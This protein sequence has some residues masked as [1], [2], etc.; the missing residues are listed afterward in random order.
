[1][2]VNNMYG[3]TALTGGVSGCLDA[4]NGSRLK[5]GDVD[6]VMDSGAN[7]SFYRLNETS[8]AA[9]S[10]PTVIS[11]DTNAGSKRHI[12]ASATFDHIHLVNNLYIAAGK[13][14]DYAG[15]GVPGMTSRLLD[16]Y[17]R[18]TFTPTIESTG[19]G[20]AL[21][22]TYQIGRYEKIGNKVTVQ[23][24]LALTSHNGSGNMFIG[25]LPF[26][27]ANV[28]NFWQAADPGWFFSLSLTASNY[29]TGY[30]NPA[31]ASIILN[32]HPVG[33]GS[34]TAIPLDTAFG[35]GVSCTYFVS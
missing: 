31:E 35:V 3:R 11:P 30:I 26:V 4:I 21:G 32:Q 1:M 20:I 7:V 24:S 34:G 18:G 22:Y 17:E 10:S 16:D 6:I 5:N 9:E 33:G 8:G 15:A 27:S 14:I 29:L 23:I 19:T 2:S 28:T 13:G 12:L 25:G